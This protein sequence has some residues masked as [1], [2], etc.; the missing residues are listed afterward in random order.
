[1][2][3]LYCFLTIKNDNDDE[4][5]RLCKTIKLS[6]MSTTLCNCLEYF[7]IRFCL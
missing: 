1:M 2:L 6:E 7:S 3:N 4:D 5:I